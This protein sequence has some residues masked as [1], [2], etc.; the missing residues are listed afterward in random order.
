MACMAF[1]MRYL[2]LLQGFCVFLLLPPLARLYA[3]RPALPACRPAGPA[4]QPPHS[5]AGEEC[6]IKGIKVHPG[7]LATT[8]R[9]PR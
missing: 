7:Y 5:D 4:P 6:T 9:T 3:S 2:P 8:R 1:G